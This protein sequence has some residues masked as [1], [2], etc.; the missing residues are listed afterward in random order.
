MAEGIEDDCVAREGEVAAAPDI[1]L[2]WEGGE[3]VG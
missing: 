3:V 2:E 1:G